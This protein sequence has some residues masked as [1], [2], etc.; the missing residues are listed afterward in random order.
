MG[1]LDPKGGASSGCTGGCGAAKYKGDG[2]CDDNNNNCGCDY[3][4]GDCCKATV[5]SGTVSKAYC[6]EC[7]CKDPKNPDDENCKGECGAPGYIGDGNCDDENN[8]CGCGYDNGDC[9]GVSVGTDY[10]NECKCKDPD[11]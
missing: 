8:N 11:Y 5:P 2:N 3:D 1:C 9:C 4:G 7:K 10:C 6:N